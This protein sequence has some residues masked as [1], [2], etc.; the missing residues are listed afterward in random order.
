[1][2]GG[3][4][5]QGGGSNQ[6]EMGEAPELLVRSSSKTAGADLRSPIVGLGA[7]PKETSGGCRGAAGCSS[8]RFG[9]TAPSGSTAF[10]IGLPR[11]CLDEIRYVEH[12]EQ[13]Q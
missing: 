8:S 9:A 11:F 5:L 12:Q 10:I 7:F 4:T 2:W 6:G 1:M 3:E 13:K